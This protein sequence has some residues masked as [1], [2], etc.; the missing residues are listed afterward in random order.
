[1]TGIVAL[2]VLA[3][4]VAGVAAQWLAWRL[5]LPAIVLLFAV[6]LLLGPGL[7]LLHPEKAFGA[8]LHPLIG[9]GVAIVVFEGGLG[10]N[11]RELRAAGEG[12]V[13]LTAV[14]LPIGLGL[15]T[16][17]AHTL[18]KMSWAVAL[19]FGAITVVTGPTVVLPLLR[20]TRLQRRPASFLKWEAIVNDP[21]GALLSALTLA[22]LAAHGSANHGWLI[23][24]LLGG[25]GLAGALGIGAALG[26][27]WLFIRDLAP[28]FLKT[29]ILLALAL[30]SYALSNL[31]IDEA[32]L[33]SATVFGVALA[34]LRIPGLTELAR[35]KEAL[36]VLLVSALFIILSASLDRHVLGE[37]SWPMLFLTGA[38]LFIVRPC[39]IGLATLS[40]GLSWR[41]RVLAGWTAPRGIVAAAVA[42][43]ASTQLGSF[44]Y[45]GSELLMPAVFA[46]IAATMVIHGFTLGPLARR[47]HLTLGDSPTL[48]IVGA[49]AWTLDLAETLS[50]AGIAT[51]LVDTFPG[52]LQTARDRNLSVLQA[53]LLSEHGGDA[54]ADWRVDYLLAATPDYIYNSLICT[55][56]APDVGRHRVGQLVPPG[57]TVDDWVGL[58][59]EWRGQVVGQ[60]P[61]SFSQMRE[62][63]RKGWRFALA[64]P[65]EEPASHAASARRV[66]LLFIRANGAITFASPEAADSAPADQDRLLVFEAPRGGVDPRGAGD[67]VRR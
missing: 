23:M 7:Q 66:V 53:E 28:E 15:A 48:A 58:S 55:R 17:A 46:L 12:V 35:V 26:V 25:I 60:P 42:G 9:L 57:S 36:V 22:I 41:E 50:G 27:R 6:G 45:A 13:R 62:R 52:A 5:R 21:V 24:R 29:P 44:S 10:L 54:L 31:V 49:S 18:A 11:F 38:M 14:A 3:I 65:A 43:V 37:V 33:A 16:L 47:L 4:V 20:Q 40:T 19:L 59:R 56:L 34:N 1:M 30:G 39:A 63:F 32:G 8:G 61:M 67:R 2:W 51:L 64:G